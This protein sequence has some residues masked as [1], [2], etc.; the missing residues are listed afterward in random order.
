MSFLDN[1]RRA[2]GVKSDEYYDDRYDDEEYEE[3]EDDEPK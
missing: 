1:A 2:L 3:Y